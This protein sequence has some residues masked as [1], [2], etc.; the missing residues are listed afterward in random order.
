MST[1]TA[2]K[3]KM[4]I[5]P[6]IGLS[7]TALLI[8]QVVVMGKIMGDFLTLYAMVVAFYYGEAAGA[9]MPGSDGGQE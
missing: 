8:F 2:M 5:R 9:R 1:E 6:I 4:F 3:I 7:L